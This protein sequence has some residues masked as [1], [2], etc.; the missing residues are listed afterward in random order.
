MFKQICFKVKQI[1]YLPPRGRS[2]RKQQKKGLRAG[3]YELHLLNKKQKL[4]LK[5]SQPFFGGEGMCPVFSLLAAGSTTS[6]TRLSVSELVTGKQNSN[7]EAETLQ[8]TF[9]RQK[10]KLT[11][12]GS[13]A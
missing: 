7:K 5:S 10:L 3:P 8:A 12:K 11:L 6:P 13:F 1:Y 9:K 2:S 4:F